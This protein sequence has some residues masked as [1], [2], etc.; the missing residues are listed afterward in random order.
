M[1]IFAMVLCGDND[2]VEQFLK[3][4]Q[5]EIPHKV[6]WYKLIHGVRLTKISTISDTTNE[7]IMQFSK[8]SALPV[9][10]GIAESEMHEYD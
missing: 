5:E 8:D 2:P 6:F 4:L 3:E 7:K 9:Q 1:T 10:C